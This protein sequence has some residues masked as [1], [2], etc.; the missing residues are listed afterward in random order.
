MAGGAGKSLTIRRVLNVVVEFTVAPHLSEEQSDSGD[1]DPRQGAHGIGDL[2]AHLVLWGV[3]R[4][5]RGAGDISW[6]TW[7]CRV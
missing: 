6:L 4:G 3:T 7:F 1:T 5:V 2:P